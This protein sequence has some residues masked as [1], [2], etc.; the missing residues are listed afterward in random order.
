MPNPVFYPK[1]VGSQMFVGQAPSLNNA[2][3]LETQMLTTQ[4]TDL[5]LQVAGN[6]IN[7]PL[8]EYIPGSSP[9]GELNKV[10]PLPATWAGKP[11]MLAAPKDPRE[12]AQSRARWRSGPDLP[13]NVLHVPIHQQETDYSCGPAALLSVLRYWRAFD[14]AERDLYDLLETTPKDGTEPSKIVG[15]AAAFGLSVE[16]RTGMTTDDLRAALARGETV[17][18]DMQAWR[19]GNSARMPWENVWE[20]G[21]YAVLIGMDAKY[22]YFMDPVLKDSYAYMPLEELPRRWHDYESRHGTTQRYF[23]LGIIISG[24]PHPPGAPISAKKPARLD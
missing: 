11:V 19:A 14:G 21:H 13:A 22:A 16:M 17:I 10:R 23:G 24:K 7:V 6:A 9:F 18:L 20:D 5:A 15:A 8:D 4:N 2:S 3:G 1:M 12:V